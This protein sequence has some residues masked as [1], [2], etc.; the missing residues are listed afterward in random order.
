VA[1]NGRVELCE[2]S[3]DAVAFPATH[4]AMANEADGFVPPN[5]PTSVATQLADGI[6][7][8]LLDTYEWQDDL[9]LCH[10][11]CELGA[12]PLADT[13]G[14]VAAFLDAHPG[15]VI[16]LMFQDAISAEDTARAFDA[17][18]LSG[19]AWAWDGGALPTLGELVAADTR[20][21]VSAEVA[22]PPPDWYHHAW[23]LYVDTPY[24]FSSV[25]E[26]SCEPNRGSL[27]NPLF[28]LNHWLQDPLS[29]P[30]L[31]AEANAYDVLSGRALACAEAFGRPP[32]LVAVDWYTEGDLFAV[33][34]ALNDR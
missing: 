23:D 26:F 15:E 22:G 8:L 32:T 13:L 34:D 17:A 5:Q 7:G 6:R 9:Y 4:N 18:G 29:E 19:R 10:G 27:D 24:D 12:T 14:V 11:Y 31:A 3:I 25:D 20:L 2:R 30:E 1:C 16:H 21:V 33:V 28:L